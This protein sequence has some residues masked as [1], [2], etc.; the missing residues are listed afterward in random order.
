M[1]ALLLPHLLAEK[2]CVEELLGVL[3]QEEH[4]MQD[5][6][7]ADLAPLTERKAALL[8]RMTAL[9]RARESAQV[10]MGF[11][12]GRAGADAAA[13]ATGTTAQEAWAALLQLAEQAKAG[14]RRNGAMVHGHLDFTRNALHYLQAAALPFYGP[15]GIRKAVGGTGTRL[16]LG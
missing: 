8:D 3:A 6:L 1:S 10:A 4:A 11:E 13:A 9:D 5:G 15:D 14:N 12:P 2:A 7:F 16:A